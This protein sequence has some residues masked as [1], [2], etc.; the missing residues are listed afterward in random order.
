MV[1]NGRRY[2]TTGRDESGSR[3]QSRMRDS[4]GYT[5]RHPTGY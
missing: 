2:D 3:W 1:V 5:V 4:S